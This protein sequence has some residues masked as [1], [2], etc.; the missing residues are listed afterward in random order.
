MIIIT[1]RGLDPSKKTYFVESSI[2]SFEDQLSRGFGLEFDLQFTKDNKI[3]VLHDSNLKRISLGRDTREICDINANEILA[4]E[5]N[6][7]HIISFDKLLEL[8][9][10]KQ[11]PKAISAIHIKS[12]NQSSSKL[13]IILSYLEKTTPDKFIIFD[14]TLSTAKY[15]KENNPGLN[16]APS[17]AHSFDIER[18]NSTVGNTL[19]N[20][21]TILDNKNLFDWVWL[22]EWD[23]TDKN[24]GTKTLYKKETFDKLREANIKIALVSPELHATSPNLLGREK[25]A[26]AETKEKLFDRMEEI[27][28]LEPDAICT[29]YPDQ[30]KY[31]LK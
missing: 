26:D 11:F 23:K 25:H 22:D 5:F 2:E 4:M 31:L 24:N 9:D 1:H 29:D 17:V 30:I 14:V 15:L 28:N 12:E 6:N 16:L 10:D 19:I 18:Y 21:E 3:V 7:C 8:I 13:D 20:L 27:I